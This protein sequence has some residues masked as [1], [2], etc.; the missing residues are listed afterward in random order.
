MDSSMDMR[1]FAICIAINFVVI[2][3]WRLSELMRR[4]FTVT[5]PQFTD[6]KANVGSSKPHLS[7]LQTHTT[8]N[9]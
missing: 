3:D 2:D 9:C 5:D 1:Q 7:V 6:F 4:C 8:N